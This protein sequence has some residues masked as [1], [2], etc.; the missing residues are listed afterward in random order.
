M[1][2]KLMGQCIL[3][4]VDHKREKESNF[5]TWVMGWTSEFRRRR[6]GFWGKMPRSV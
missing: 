2:I 6:K 5:L 3:S 4:D 1:Q